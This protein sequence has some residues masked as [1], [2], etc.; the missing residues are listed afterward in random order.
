MVFNVG[1]LK[2]K[3]SKILVLM[4]SLVYFASYI[5]RINFAV[6]LVKICSEMNLEK[7][8]LAIVITSLTIAYGIGQV[9]SGFLGDKFKPQH[10]LSAGLLLAIICN[11]LMYFSTNVTV[12]SI[13]WGVNGFAHA[14]LWPPIV[15]LLT[16]CLNDKEYDY[17]IVRVI[18]GS[19]IA[20]IFLYLMCPL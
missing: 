18:W 20:T 8:S 12:M 16:V 15:K 2:S 6:M 11:I 5:M 17:S 19:S 9:I 10:L 14:L 4:C 1:V 13:V 3:K 7:T